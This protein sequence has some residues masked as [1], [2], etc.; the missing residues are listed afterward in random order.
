MNYPPP[1]PST[2]LATQ[3]ALKWLLSRGKTQSLLSR[4][5]QEREMRGGSQRRARV[6]CPSAQA[7]NAGL[8]VSLDLSGFLPTCVSTTSCL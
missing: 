6:L 1:G 4:H 8:K 2:A 7:E 3:Q 5:V